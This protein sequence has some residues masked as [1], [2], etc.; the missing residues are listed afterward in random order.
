MKLYS[1]IHVG[2]SGKYRQ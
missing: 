2:G 1:S